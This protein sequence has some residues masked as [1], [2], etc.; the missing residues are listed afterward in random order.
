VRSG[1]EGLGYGKRKEKRVEG[2]GGWGTEKWCGGEM[3]G[4]WR[5]GKL[6]KLRMRT[7]R[8]CI[9]AAKDE[10]RVHREQNICAERK[11]E[12]WSSSV[13]EAL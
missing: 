4:G 2:G 9:G 10:N 6:E 5:E 3:R 1:V 12:R 11:E 8:R 7:D 13:I